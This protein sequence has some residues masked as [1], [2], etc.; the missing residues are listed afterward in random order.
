MKPNLFKTLAGIAV[1][2]LLFLTAISPAFGVVAN[3]GDA[4]ARDIRKLLEVSGIYD[5]LD[6]MK[7]NLLNQ[8]SMGFSGAYP[9]TPDAFWEEYY[10][11]IT[12][13]D[14][15]VLVERMIPVYDKNMSHEV[16]RKLIEMF[17]TPFWQEW[18]VKMPAISREA[19]LIGSEWGQAILQ[20]DPFNQQLKALIE[21]HDLEGLN[22]Q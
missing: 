11:L 10:Q 12:Q 17:E 4:K 16:I 14:I 6:L 19:G 15:D 22:P 3:P 1:T 20:S 21:K 13:K 8:Y 7:N 18:K 2:A 9:K 5:Q